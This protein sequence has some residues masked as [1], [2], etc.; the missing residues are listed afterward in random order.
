M[1]TYSQ[2]ATDKM[3]NSR[4]ILNKLLKDVR[5][6][7]VHIIVF[8]LFFNLILFASPIYML[9]IY[10]R[11]LPARSVET[12]VWLS[13][14]VVTLLIIMVA[15]D[16]ARHI[17]F[18]RLSG[19]FE[20]RISGHLVAHTLQREGHTAQADRSNIVNEIDQ[21]R[22]LLS[23]GH[24]LH[25]LDAMLSPLFIVGIAFFHPV[26]ALIAVFGGAV[27]IIVAMVNHTCV[28]R[29]ME[30][31]RFRAVRGFN[32]TDE[33]MRKAD[34]IRALGMTSAKMQRW[35]MLRHLAVSGHMTASDRS[36][37]VT[38]LSRSIKML[39]QSIMLGAGAYLAIHEAISAGAIIAASILV[40]RALAPIEASISAWMELIKA[41]SA[42]G[43]LLTLLDH[44]DAT[45][46]VFMPMN[47]RGHLDVESLS[48]A[49]EGRSVLRDINFTAEPGQTI[50]ILGP[51][52]C[53]KTTLIRHLV[54]IC[55]G[56]TGT[57]RLDDADIVSLPDDARRRY[58]GYLPQ[59]LDLLDGSIV[60]TISRFGT[61]E[62]E[63][64]VKTAQLARVH[65]MILRLPEG[66]G[67]RVGADGHRLSGGQ[68][69]QLA[70]A[71]ALYGDPSF[72]VLDEPSSYLDEAG[73][74][75]LLEIIGELKNRGTT[76]CI[77][78]HQASFIRFADRALIINS[79][80]EARFGHPPDLFKPTLRAVPRSK[81]V[82]RGK[83]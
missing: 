27:L 55:S 20:R 24:L 49:I 63:D 50:A 2:D 43:E 74:R 73:E 79:K 11:I 51:S 83:A 4:E 64:I 1:A 77:A 60:E 37:F 35:T 6:F 62:P 67:T 71:R 48:C 41:R 34:A 53:G 32:Q 36:A 29:S 39:I 52:G 8:S 18:V 22:N 72:V 46:R 38:A 76:L 44:E 9:Q 10:N 58:I 69:Q 40:G 23:K 16:A 81:G 45:P 15:V 26:L 56:L 31:A 75:Q 80:G 30:E 28:G 17:M 33:M 54:G 5:F 59:D 12:L 57:A 61:P 3:N 68:R 47:C 66:Y 7:G 65:S 82:G 19:R 42:L 78:T 13:L 70:L 25:L 21:I 14:L